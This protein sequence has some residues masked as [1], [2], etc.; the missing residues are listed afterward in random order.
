MR[1]VTPTGIV[2]AHSNI[3]QSIIGIVHQLGGQ[4]P[5]WYCNTTSD[6]E[7]AL[8]RHCAFRTGAWLWAEPGSYDAGVHL[9]TRLARCGLSCAPDFRTRGG[10]YFYCFRVC[11]L[12][13]HTIC[14]VPADWVYHPSHGLRGP[15]R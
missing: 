4:L 9:K 15:S 10:N 1:I 13:C 11:G 6:P 8:A 12:N 5:D 7:E 2:Y 3:E 14:S